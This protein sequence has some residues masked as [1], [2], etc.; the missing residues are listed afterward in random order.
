MKNLIRLWKHTVM[1]LV[2]ALTLNQLFGQGVIYDVVPSAYTWETQRYYKHNK[3]YGSFTHLGTDI[4]APVGSEVCSMA[5]GIVVEVWNDG[6]HSGMGNGIRI[7]HPGC[8]KNGQDI[9]TLYLHLQTQDKPTTLFIIGD[10]VSKGQKIGRI[11]D[12]GSGIVHLH[13]EIRYFTTLCHPQYGRIHIPGDI[14]ASEIAQNDWENAE[15]YKSYSTI[16]SGVDIFAGTV[17]TPKK[18]KVWFVQKD[19]GDNYSVGELKIGNVSI[20]NT[21]ITKKPSEPITGKCTFEI[22]LTSG[23]LTGLTN[24]SYDFSFTI[25]GNK[26]YFGAKQI[27]FLDPSSFTDVKIDEW[28]KGFVYWGAQSG[29]FKGSS[30]VTF[31]VESNLKRGQ[32]AKVIVSAAVNL[33]LY[34]IDVTTTKN[35]TFSDC[36]P[37]NAYFPYVQTLRNR[38]YVMVDSKFEPNSEITAAQFAK[39]LCNGLM[40]SDADINQHTLYNSK[41]LL[42]SKV[43]IQTKDATLQVYLDRIS[44]IVSIFRNEKGKEFVLNLCSGLA[45]ITHTTV[46]GNQF[47]VNGDNPVSRVAMAKIL[48]NTYVFKEMTLHKKRGTLDVSKFVAVGNHFE[49]TNLTTGNQPKI[50]SLPT[51]VISGQPI[52]L[53]AYQSDYFEGSPLFFYWCADNGGMESLATNHRKIKFIAP[54]VTTPTEV[55]VYVLIGTANGKTDEL[56]HTLTVYPAGGVDIAPTSQSTNLTFANV[57]QTSMTLNWT[58]GNGSGCLVIGRENGTVMSAIPDNGITYAPAP[59]FADGQAILWRPVYVGSDNSV[60]ITGLKANTDYTFAIFEYNGSGTTIKYITTNPANGVQRTPDVLKNSSL[61]VTIMPEGAQNYGRWYISGGDGTLKKSGESIS[62]LPSGTY[63]ISLYDINTIT[64]YTIGDLPT[65]N[66]MTSDSKSVFAYYNEGTNPL[67]VDFSWSPTQIVAGVPVTFTGTYS[68]E[69]L[70]T[71]EGA[72]YSSYNWLTASNVIFAKEGVYNVTYKI[73]DVNIGRSS[74]ITKKI[75]VLNS[76]VVYPELTPVI[77]PRFGTLALA[78]EYFYLEKYGIFQ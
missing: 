5:D 50:S 58:R 61:T 3:V 7:K 21:A 11:G 65:V 44:K 68:T 53:T 6:V 25:N 20:D 51:S 28:Y 59:N 67:Q 8:G 29:I 32:M 36:L 52:E 9:Y 13:F 37:G 45:P 22:N 18:V 74:T 66:L 33:G 64:G 17:S 69:M 26:R 27:Y 48:N 70:W 23:L 71:F 47:L 56:Q 63:K 62:G 1:M 4:N 77:K 34:D 35:G 49:L 54:T 60:N 38:E 73:T 19:A 39:I 75:E 42:G 16:N 30:P 55:N 57:T 41:G 72:N 40:I 46:T 12:T 10:K 24:Q 43:L 31:G 78:N 14:T 76:N 15:T 2:L